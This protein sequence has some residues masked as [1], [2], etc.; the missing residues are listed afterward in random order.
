MS[1]GLNL[2][3]TRIGELLRHERETLADLSHRLRTPLTA[4]RIDAESLRGDEEMM[5]R[6]VADVDVLT[7]TVNE[8]LDLP[9]KARRHVRA[10]RALPP[11]TTAPA[12]SELEHLFD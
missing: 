2:L 4:L 1:D 6:V 12:G 7:R 5:N 3:A 8:M 11:A 9:L 10:R